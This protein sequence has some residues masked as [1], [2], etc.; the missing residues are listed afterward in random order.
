MTYS[1]SAGA[2][3]SHS[4]VDKSLY[5]LPD[6]TLRHLSEPP[7]ALGSQEMLCRVGSLLLC[8]MD[9]SEL[10]PQVL[11]AFAQALSCSAAQ[12][13]GSMPTLATSMQHY[14]IGTLPTDEEKSILWRALKLPTPLAVNDLWCSQ[15]TQLQARLARAVS[16]GTLCLQDSTVFSAGSWPGWA[17][18]VFG[19]GANRHL[20]LLPLAQT[21]QA[22]QSVVTKEDTTTVNANTLNAIPGPYSE[23]FEGGT[24][25]FP[26]VLPPGWNRTPTN[27]PTWL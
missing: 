1:Q 14:G 22:S 5:S 18:Q 27:S 17:E 16:T 12:L 23:D 2:T 3:Q 13:L 8:P 10:W 19:E 24:S 26:G 6:Q 21:Q 11:A 4:S 7:I 20:L 9:A 25:G 15:M